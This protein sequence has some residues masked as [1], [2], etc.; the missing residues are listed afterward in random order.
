M[1]LLKFLEKATGQPASR[2][3]ESARLCVDEAKNYLT[4]VVTRRHSY[5]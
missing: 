5:C 1:N 2:A 3:S 4:F